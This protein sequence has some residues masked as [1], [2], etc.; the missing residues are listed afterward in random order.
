MPDV[1]SRCTP[2]DCDND[3]VEDG[4]PTS[5]AGALVVK[6]DGATKKDDMEGI[7]EDKTRAMYGMS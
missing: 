4:I 3:E 1:L 6:R 2:D 5:K 7:S